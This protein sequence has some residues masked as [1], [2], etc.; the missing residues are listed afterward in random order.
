VVPSAS[1]MDAAIMPDGR[2]RWPGLYAHGGCTRACG[3]PYTPYC[4]L[5]VSVFKLG[6]IWIVLES[7]SVPYTKIKM[8]QLCSSDG[9]FDITVLK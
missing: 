7:F 4:S 3:M 5:Q 8:V 6:T 9:T 1:E 2:S